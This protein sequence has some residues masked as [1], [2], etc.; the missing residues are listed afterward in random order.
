MYRALWQ[1]KFA[2]WRLAIVRVIT[3]TCY[4]VWSFIFQLI[5]DIATGK[6]SGSFVVLG[7][8]IVLYMIVM[9]GFGAVDSYLANLLRFQVL[10]RLRTRVMT[11]T[12]QMSP[13]TF[14]AVGV[15]SSVGKLTKQADNIDQLYYGPLLRMSYLVLQVIIAMIAT[16]TI[17]PKITLAV[18]GLSVPALIFPFLMKKRLANAADQVV[19][20]IDRYTSRVTELLQGFPLLKYGLA[21]PAALTQHAGVNTALVTAQTRD[22][23]LENISSGVSMLLSDIVYV[24]AWFLGALLVHAG[25]LDMGQLVAFS[26]LTGFMTYPLLELSQTVPQIISGNQAA[27]ALAKDLATPSPQGTVPLALQDGPVFARFSHASLTVAQQPILTDVSLRLRQHD[28]TLL[29]GASGSG[30]TT[31]VRLLLGELAP[32]SGT[33]WLGEHDAA[34][35]TRE[36]V[37]GHIGIMAQQN[38]VFKTSVAANLTLFEKNQPA[39]DLKRVL[40]RAGLGEWLSHHA[41]TTQLSND[42]PLLSGGEK[43]RLAL[44]RLLLKQGDYAIFDELTAGLDAPIAHRLLRDLFTLPTGFLLITHT[45]DHAAFAAA[46]QI[47]VLAGGRVVASGR[48]SDAEVQQAL[49]TLRLGK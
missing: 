42:S 14:A 13:E 28:K 20:S 29:V 2:F 16:V 15:G 31:L 39:E 25:Q 34:A 6:R 23:R 32:T 4:V 48:Q 46:D 40:T 22:Q 37:Y 35:L 24:A 44:A 45:Y 21:T 10:A 36:S 5:V 33:V 12:L 17:S 49:A 18:L 43:Q 9:D 27:N 3:V 7:M 47:I 8:G 1:N 11:H 26:S 41:L 19:I 38:Y 30:K